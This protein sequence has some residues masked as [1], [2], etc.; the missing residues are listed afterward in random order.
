M[1]L[2]FTCMVGQGRGKGLVFG[3]KLLPSFSRRCMSLCF[4]LPCFPQLSCPHT[5]HVLIG[6]R[7]KSVCFWSSATEFVAKKYA[8]EAAVASSSPVSSSSCFPASFCFPAAA[9]T[10]LL[11]TDEK[12][13]SFPQVLHFFPLRAAGQSLNVILRP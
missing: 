6:R 2:T 9:L 3:C 4:S 13:P 8:E 11:Q 5:F 12:C 7:R 1:W 10:L